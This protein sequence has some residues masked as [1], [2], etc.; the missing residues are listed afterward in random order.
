MK[1]IKVL[2]R[3]DLKEYDFYSV[4][5]ISKTLSYNVNS[6]SEWHLKCIRKD[7][8]GWNVCITTVNSFEMDLCRKKKG[9]CR[10]CIFLSRNQLTILDN[11]GYKDLEGHCGSNDLLIDMLLEFK[12]QNNEPRFTYKMINAEKIYFE[13]TK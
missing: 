12:Q 8:L 4:R 9:V 6:C 2:I 13:F 10:V 1:F 5:Q 7:N 11:Q 3:Q